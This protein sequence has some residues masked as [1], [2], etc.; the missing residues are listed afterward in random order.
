M[1]GPKYLLPLIA[2]VDVAIS[3]PAIGQCRLCDQ[4]TTQRAEDTPDG[5]VQLQVETA[6]SF[7]RL[8]ISGTG[9]GAATV[10]PDGAHNIEGSVIEIGARAMVGTVLV[11]GE[12]NRAVR[13]DIPRRIDLYSLRGGRITLDDVVTDIKG[14]PRLDA[15][16]NLSFHFGGRLVVNGDTDGQYRGDLPITVE[17]L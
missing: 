5:D 14:A 16:G 1:G 3:S 13:V 7:D 12:A 8:I 15:A 9:V 2:A 11:H 6:L 4:P 17:Y 10:R